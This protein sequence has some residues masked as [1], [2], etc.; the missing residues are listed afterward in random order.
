MIWSLETDDSRNICGQG[1]F[2]ILQSINKIING[3]GGTV[4]ETGGETK[5]ETETETEKVTE[6]TTT[7]T[8]VFECTKNG[9]FRDPNNCAIFYFC[10]S[11]TKYRYDCAPGLVFD[12]AVGA[13]NW[14]FLVTC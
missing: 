11:F 3:N 2:P 14:D 5:T 7:K 12:E 10:V 9:H 8:T 6:I 13:C 4:S 1:K